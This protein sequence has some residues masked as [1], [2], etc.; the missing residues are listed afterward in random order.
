MHITKCDAGD[1][2]S[3]KNMRDALGPG[4]IDAML[5]Q[6]IQM[7][8]MVLPEDKRTVDHLEA[9]IRRMIDRAMRDLRDDATAFGIGTDQ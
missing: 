2:E 5:R 9:E 1:E 3:R 4:Q 7:C 6:A 8:W